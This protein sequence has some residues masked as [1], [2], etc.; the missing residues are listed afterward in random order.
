MW[1]C[2]FYIKQ[3]S[4][5]T[6]PLSIYSNHMLLPCWVCIL[7]GCPESVNMLMRRYYLFFEDATLCAILYTITKRCFL[8]VVGWDALYCIITCMWRL[9]RKW[10]RQIYQNNRD[11][12]WL[13]ITKKPKPVEYN[14]L[15]REIIHWVWINGKWSQNQF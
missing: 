14:E 3:H 15:R 2:A 12:Q 10:H 1:H 11:M 13:Y 9:L 8:V 4:F 7:T 5:H 6:N